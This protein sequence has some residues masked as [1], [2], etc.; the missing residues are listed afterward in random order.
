MQEP[1]DTSSYFTI[2][3]EDDAALA[4]STPV[5]DPSTGTVRQQ[6]IAAAVER[7]KEEYKPIHA[8][9]EYKVSQDPI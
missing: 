7:S 9:T 6:R 1:V 3:V 5:S 4:S 2:A 8:Y